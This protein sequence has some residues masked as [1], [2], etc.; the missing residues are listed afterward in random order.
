VIP[1]GCSI[2]IASYITTH[3]CLHAKNSESN[4]NVESLHIVAA[5][6]EIGMTVISAVLSFS[7]YLSQTNTSC[8]PNFCYLSVYCVIWYF[9]RY[10]LLNATWRIFILYC[11]ILVCLL[12]LLDV[13]LLVALC[14]CLL[15][16]MFGTR[17][18]IFSFI[19]FMQLLHSCVKNQEF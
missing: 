7:D 9:L 11:S 3:K 13:R 16:Y 1:T 19:M 2:Y 15:N 12:Q 8:V 6:L 18:A 17:A 10:I 4:V 5:L 14:M